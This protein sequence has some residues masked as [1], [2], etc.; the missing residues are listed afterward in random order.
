MAFFKIVE[1]YKDDDFKIVLHN[2]IN[3]SFHNVDRIPHEWYFIN[4]LMRC[5]I[6][7][8]KNIAKLF[9]DFV[10]QFY[11]EY[12]WYI[13]PCEDDVDQVMLESAVHDFNFAKVYQF[14]LEGPEILDKSMEFG[15]MVT[16]FLIRYRNY[17]LVDY[18]G[19]KMIYTAQNNCDKKFEKYLYDGYS[20][21]RVA[22]I[23]YEDGSFKKLPVLPT[24]ELD[25][26]INEIIETEN[27]RYFGLV[28][29]KKH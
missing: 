15:E 11:P 20:L 27:G 4:L 17:S 3:R 14:G 16:D 5:E 21:Q 26:P 6:K 2:L 8:D 28:K 19:T 25:I 12:E 7:K 18:C 13:P 10:N 24:R 29:N 22:K 23:Y 1:N 9:N